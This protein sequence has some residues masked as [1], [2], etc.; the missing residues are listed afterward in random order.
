MTH[1]WILA[2]DA[3][4]YEVKGRTR[5][6]V[7]KFRSTIGPYRHLHLVNADSSQMEAGDYIVE[8]GDEKLFVGNIAWRECHA[9]REPRDI[10][11]AHEETKI[12]VLVA[13]HQ[14]GKTEGNCVVIG[15]PIR[16]MVNRDRESMEKM[17]KGEHTI[18]VNNV[19]KTFYI[20]EVK[21]APEGSGAYFS[22]E[23]RPEDI[24][25]IIDAGSGTFNYLRVEDGYFIDRKSGTLAFG[26]E[27]DM[28]MTEKQMA[29]AILAELRGKWN[30]YEPTYLCGG[31][32]EYLLPHIKEHFSNIKLIRP[33][34][35]RTNGHKAY[36]PQ[37]ANAFGFYSMGKAVFVD[38]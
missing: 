10:S 6:D 36:S 31:I 35:Y 29:V 19:R 28:E 15:Q 21:V 3:G 26:A 17:L 24:A 9:I 34:L 23:D 16:G 27:T 5:D 12:R 1:K 8:Y 30:L 20:E 32:A 37:Y 18:T 7:F 2:I 38:E 14:Y 11:K 33:V 22:M 25:N 4:A 13:V